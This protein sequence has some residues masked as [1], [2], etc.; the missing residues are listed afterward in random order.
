MWCSLKKRVD[1]NEISSDSLLR[2]SRS[3]QPPRRDTGVPHN[4][5]AAKDP[6]LH[7]E[8]EQISLSNH[9]YPIDRHESPT[10][11]HQLSSIELECPRA[12]DLQSTSY[13]F[14]HPAEQQNAL[15]S[16][17]EELTQTHTD[18]VAGFPTPGSQS[19]PT[20][21]DTRLDMPSQ[22]GSWN[23]GNT[24]TEMPAWFADDD[25]D[26]S[27]LNSEIMMSTAQWLPLGNASQ[28]HHEPF[29]NTPGQSTGHM[30][31]CRE[32]VVQKHWYTFMGTSRTGQTTPDTGMERTQ[33]DETYRASLAAKLQPDIPF[34]P[35]PS[36]DFLVR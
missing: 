8:N 33:V 11:P 36:T 35:L 30:T 14:S 12:N 15:V 17:V 13:S 16:N 32:D 2:H 21:P 18:G 26:I 29:I 19:N 31:S 7:C 34:L 27:A 22:D 23:F 4:E 25:F 6:P 5:S 9:N 3:H 20:E 10:S 1:T 24:N 28:W